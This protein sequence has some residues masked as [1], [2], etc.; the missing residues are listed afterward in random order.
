MKELYEGKLTERLLS[1]PYEPS[2][3]LSRGKFVVERHCKI[4]GL[5]VIF[6]YSMDNFMEVRNRLVDDV[7]E[8]TNDDP[9]VTQRNLMRHTELTKRFD[10]T[11]KQIYLGSYVHLDKKNF[12]RFG[13]PTRNRLYILPE[14]ERLV[15]VKLE[16][17][18]KYLAGKVIR[19]IPHLAAV[20]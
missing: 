15:L 2:K 17:L 12:E 13:S 6:L 18:G 10:K 5:D 8:N 7:W 9:A 4:S 11:R 16:D 20:E 19:S 3:F 1:I 14:K